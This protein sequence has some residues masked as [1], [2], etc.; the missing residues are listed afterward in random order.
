MNRVGFD[1]V[2][3]LNRSAFGLDHTAQYPLFTPDLIDLI[4]KLIP[5]ERQERVAVSVTVTPRKR[6]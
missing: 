4:H 6:D 5:A 3:V 1:N 2:Q